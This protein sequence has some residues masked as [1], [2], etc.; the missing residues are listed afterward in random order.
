MGSATEK[1]EQGPDWR[2]DRWEDHR[3]LRWRKYSPSLK[4]CQLLWKV[5]IQSSI[6]SK[7]PN[8]QSKRPKKADKKAYYLANTNL[9][10]STYVPAPLVEI[11]PMAESRGRTCS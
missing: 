10:V 2:L 7:R 3:A 9:F 5:S 6:S 1:L 8:V 11:R 4:Q